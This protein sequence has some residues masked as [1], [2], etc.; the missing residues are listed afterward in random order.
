[1]ILKRHSF[2]RWK[3]DIRP[4]KNM[5]QSEH[6]GDAGLLVMNWGE[7]VYGTAVP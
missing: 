7:K 4:D 3:W 1:V 2:W 5:S 6:G